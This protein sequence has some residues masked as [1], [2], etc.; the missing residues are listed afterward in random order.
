[1]KQATLDRIR[2]FN[3]H[4]TN[5]VLIH[6][7]GKRFGHFA[8]LTHTGR[9]SGRSYRIPI[10][11]EPVEHGFVVALTYGKKV[12]WYANVKAH[13]RCSLFWK[14]RDYNLVNPEWIEPESGLMAF[15]AVLRSALRRAGIQYFLRL[16][17]QA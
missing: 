12:D 9:V 16:T 1:M 5:K 11:A 15:P 10:I 7:A 14:G 8:I 3:K 2:V 13:G 4:V 17:I 6:I